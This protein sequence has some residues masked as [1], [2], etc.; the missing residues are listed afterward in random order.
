M[1]LVSQPSERRLGLARGAYSSTGHSLQ[2]TASRSCSPG[3]AL[4][5]VDDS[6]SFDGQV[7]SLPARVNDSLARLQRPDAF[8][9][10]CSYTVHI[11]VIYIHTYPS[12]YWRRPS[13]RRCSTTPKER[14]RE[15]SVSRGFDTRQAAAAKKS[16]VSSV[17]A[18]RRGFINIR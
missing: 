6:A 16:R 3:S 4:A 14:R 12:S 5:T 17:C 11:R 7:R 2:S 10:W 1:W 13:R 8:S 9:Q 15:S 18:V